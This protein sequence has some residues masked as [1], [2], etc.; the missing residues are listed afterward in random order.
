MI[1]YFLQINIYLPAQ[2][3]A[4]ITCIKA[5]YKLI[6]LSSNEGIKQLKGGH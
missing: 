2:N 6:A 5:S 3:A 4:D 1:D